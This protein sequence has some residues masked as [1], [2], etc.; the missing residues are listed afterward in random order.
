MSSTSPLKTL[1]KGF[2]IL[3]NQTD[4]C[5]KALQAKLAKQKSISL[6]DEANLIV[7]QQV[8]EKLEKATTFNQGLEV[9]DEEERAVVEH[10][11]QLGVDESIQLNKKTN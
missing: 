3:Q 6:A 9:L 8:I 7:E 5:Q 4:R 2:Y 1:K 10:L 11:K